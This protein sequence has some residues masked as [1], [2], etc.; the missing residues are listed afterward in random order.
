MR[1]VWPP[2]GCTAKAAGKEQLS[3]TVS[4]TGPRA[5]LGSEGVRSSENTDTLQQQGEKDRSF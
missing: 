3:H 5:W 1:N 4:G 2:R